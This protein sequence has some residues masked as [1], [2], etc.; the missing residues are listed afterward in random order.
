MSQDL[1]T[2]GAK[3][4]RKRAQTAPTRKDAP[5]VARAK[6]RPASN[7]TQPDATGE[8]PATAGYHQFLERKSQLGGEFG[9]APLWLPDSLFDFQRHLDEWALRKGRAAVF[10]DCG[11]GKSLVQ[12]V[13]A[14]NV[15][16]HTNRPVLILTPL[17]V[18]DQTVRE[19]EKFGIEARRTRDGH[20]FTGINVTNYE[21]LHRFDPEDF[22]GVVCDESSIL[23]HFTG[24]TQKQV[25]RFTSKHRYRL[26]CTATAAPNDYTELGTSSE[27]L[28]E[29]GYSDMLSRFFVQRDKKKSFR[30][31]DVR[32]RKSHYQKLAL[33]VS[34]QIG[35]WRMKP[36][37]ELPFWKWVCSWARACRKPSDLGFPDDG[38]VLPPLEEHQHVVEPTRPAD[39]M[40]FTMSARGLK[41]ER[42]ERRRTLAERSE[43]VA[44]LVAASDCAVVWCHLNPEGDAL[45][46]MIPDA[47]QIKGADSDDKKEE[48]YRAFAAGEIKK[49]ISKPKIGA[50][51][52]NWHHCAHVVTYA[53]HSWEQYY[54]SV[55]R[56]WR[57]GQQRPV[58]VDVIST[59]GEEHVRESMTR[60]AR[61]AE[62]MFAQLISQM[63]D[64]MGVGRHEYTEKVRKPEWL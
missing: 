18:S 37:A 56:C 33:R 3:R 23:K 46:R 1:K 28:G 26:L 10:A 50:W 38:F 39:G 12:L 4:A 53:T 16:R 9:F 20:A 36:H 34:Q 47:V 6:T 45:E 63:N 52:L 49:L 58:R 2:T 42:D 60:K 61:A 15:V 51:G 41:A 59:T 17:A 32:G 29:L 27:A 21:R 40:L 64:A 14:E 44:E 48:T 57:F 11:L 24:A 30:M 35:Q 8:S 25:T 62:Q 5:A 43:K 31:D 19:A 7:A 13:W 55:R 54:Q 22:A